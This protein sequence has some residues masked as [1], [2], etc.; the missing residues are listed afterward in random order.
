M[1][2][3]SN[4]VQRFAGTWVIRVIVEMSYFAL[5]PLFHLIMSA[6]H[7]SPIGSDNYLNCYMKVVYY[8]ITSTPG[9][10][11]IHFRINLRTQVFFEKISFFLFCGAPKNIF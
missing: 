11:R 4:C 10:V 1:V 3:F 7:K 5:F 6:L 9:L 2:N 8:N